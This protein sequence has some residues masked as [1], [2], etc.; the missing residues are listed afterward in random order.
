[1]L[2]RGL[3]HVA[4]V[5]EYA[6]QV[7]GHCGE[8]LSSHDGNTARALLSSMCP[9]AS[10]LGKQPYKWEFASNL[11]CVFSSGRKV[12]TSLFFT[13]G[14]EC[15]AHSRSCSHAKSPTSAEATHQRSVKS[16]RLCLKSRG[17]SQQYNPSFSSRV[18]TMEKACHPPECNVSQYLYK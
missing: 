12:E 6:S 15:Y 18:L 11:G 10:I 8:C 7:D 1:M 13:L 3:P 4:S 16:C 5:S 9:G 17:C 14:M 2:H